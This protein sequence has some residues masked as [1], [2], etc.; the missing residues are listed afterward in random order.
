MIEEAAIVEAYKRFFSGKKPDY[1]TSIDEETVTA[2]YGE[3]DYAGEFEFPLDVDQ[4]T[5]RIVAPDWIVARFE[6]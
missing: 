1:S 3:L 4:E 5:Y 2:G 6:N